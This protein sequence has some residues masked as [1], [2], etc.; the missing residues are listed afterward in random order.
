MD[1]EVTFTATIV[2]KVGEDGNVN[3]VHILLHGPDHDAD[4]ETKR[5]AGLIWP[6]LFD[7]PETVV[8]EG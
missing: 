6:P 4:E 2:C 7:L 8:W 3:K 1:S 5:V